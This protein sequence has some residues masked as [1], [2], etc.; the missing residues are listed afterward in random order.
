MIAVL[1]VILEDSVPYVHFYRFIELDVEENAEAHE[2]ALVEHFKRDQ[3]FESLK[4][5]LVGWT[6]DG[7]KGK[8]KSFYV[9]L[10]FNTS[11]SF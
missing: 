3:I 9:S 5:N 8:P 10:C 1:F 4:K 11:I 2:K 6:S 7:A